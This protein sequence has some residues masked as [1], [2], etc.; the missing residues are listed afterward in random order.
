MLPYATEQQVLKIVEQKLRESGGGSTPSKDEI[1]TIV[2]KAIDEGEIVIPT[3][4]SGGTQL[5]KHA[6]N[7]T[8]MYEGDMY[9]TTCTFITASDVSFTR[10]SF[11]VL[12]NG[13]YISGVI[14]LAP[15]W[16]MEEEGPL[17][18]I[19]ASLGSG[20]NDRMLV[21]FDQDGNPMLIE[22]QSFGED[23]VTAI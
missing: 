7:L 6:V 5:Y 17:N 10:K 8:V 12:N 15:L 13:T 21:A 18:Q 11:E 19:I 1:I 20:T 4:T 9:N 3:P 23:T 2:N 14:D 22:Y 16:G